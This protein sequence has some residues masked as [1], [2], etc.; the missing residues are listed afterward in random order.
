MNTHI[1]ANSVEAPRPIR[2]TT[3]RNSGRR[4]TSASDPLLKRIFKRSTSGFA[5][6]LASV[7]LVSTHPGMAQAIETQRVMAQS[8]N[9]DAEHQDGIVSMIWSDTLAEIIGFNKKI[10]QS[11]SKS[12][13]T[14][15]IELFNAS[16]A[17]GQ[18]TIVF[19]AINNNCYSVDGVENT[20]ICPSRL[21]VISEGKVRIIKEFEN[22]PIAIKRGAAGYD[23]T[24]NRDQSY[25][26]FITFDR[27]AGQLNL[28]ETLDGKTEKPG[29]LFK[30]NQ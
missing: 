27:A 19:S 11:G 20:I 7:L 9:L 13:P 1:P 15:I 5:F 6:Y 10:Q 22:L 2:T 12:K 23:E 30:F 26:T 29:L 16:F 25:A 8:L 21:A 28:S 3:L 17:D 24:S 14:S 4:S 18:K